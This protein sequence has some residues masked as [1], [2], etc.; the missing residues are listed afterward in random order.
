MLMLLTVSAFWAQVP[1]WPETVFSS[2]SKDPQQAGGLELLEAVCPGAVATDVKRGDGRTGIGCPSCPDYTFGAPRGFGFSLEAVTFGH[3]LSPTSEDAVLW[4]TGCEGHVNYGGG[5]ILL[6]RKPQRWSML[7]YK[8]GVVTAQ[9]HKVPL[10]DG[11]EILVCIGTYS[12]MGQVYEGLYVEDLRNP[13]P[14]G[15][16]SEGTFFETLDNTCN[17]AVGGPTIGDLISA[18]IDKVEFSASKDDGPP[19]VS[20]TASFGKKQT[21]PEVAQACSANPPADAHAWDAPDGEAY[22]ATLKIVPPTKRYR[23][24]FLYHDHGYKPAPSSVD[25]VR[26]FKAASPVQ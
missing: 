9:C 23:M 1:K 2:D 10:R 7:W 25:T 8:A 12:G 24:D 6:T 17:C 14:W 4:M 15:W 21:T 18:H 13:E 22:K 26:I 19:P 3:F 11:R 16:T 20:V 5:T